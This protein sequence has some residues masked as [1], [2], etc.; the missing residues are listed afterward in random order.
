MC[1]RTL[2][3]AT[4]SCSRTS[5][6]RPDAPRSRT[7]TALSTAKRTASARYGVRPTPRPR[8]RGYRCGSVMAGASRSELC[9]VALAPLIVVGICGP[10]HGVDFLIG[11]CWQEFRWLPVGDA[12]HSQTEVRASCC[13][14]ARRRA[15]LRAAAGRRRR[16]S[17]VRRAAVVAGRIPPGATSHLPG[18]TASV[19][20]RSSLAFAR[21]RS[22]AL[23]LEAGAVLR[24]LL[25]DDAGLEGFPVVDALLLGDMLD[26]RRPPPRRQLHPTRPAVVLAIVPERRPRERLVAERAEHACIVPPASGRIAAVKGARTSDTTGEARI[27][28][29]RSA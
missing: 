5:A 21:G 10:P 22:C 18:R 11:R 14:P 8:G 3:G 27:A 19:L 20:P 1:Q 4:T 12:G 24:G 6:G 17:A 16:L 2:G 23:S 7:R 15:E 26:G 29:G 13:R 28:L 9:R 25:L